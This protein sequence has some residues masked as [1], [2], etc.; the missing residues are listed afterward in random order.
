MSEKK[1]C[2]FRQQALDRLSSPEQ[3]DRLMQVVSPK[4]WLPLG[5]L[6]IFGVLGIIWSV[7]GNIPI[8]VTGQGVLINPRR[9]VQLQSPISG[10]LKSLNFR[11]KQCVNKDEILAIID[12]S[13]KK[14]Q[15]QHQRDKLSQL[16]QQIQK[17]TLLREQKTQL[18]TETITAEIASLK[19]K[20]QDAQKLT[21]RLQEDGLHGWA[22]Q[23]SHPKT[24]P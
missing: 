8:T 10:Q 6:V 17:T 9:V 23:R 14:Q 12:P 7:F 20:L 11:D 24:W 4:D 13:D 19:Q 21:P 5:G 1:R 2:I 3:L 15:L 18:E 22:S 16:K